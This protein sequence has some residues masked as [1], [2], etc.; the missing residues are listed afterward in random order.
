MGEV[1]AGHTGLLLARH[2]QTDDNVEPIRAQGF[3]DT[4]LNEVGIAQAQAL[5]ERVAAEFEIDSLWASD[6]SPAVT[7]ATSVGER[8]GLKTKF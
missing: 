7:T 3:R 8:I 4:P 1:L 2:G 5:A 6:L